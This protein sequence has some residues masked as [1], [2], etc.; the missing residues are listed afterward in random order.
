MID[1]LSKYFRREELSCKCGCGF[2]T[3]DSSLHS[4]LVLVRLFCGGAVNVN[5]GCRCELHNFNVGGA[6][7][8]QHL[9]GRA[10]DIW[11]I[12]KTPL[13]IFEFIDKELKWTGGLIL[14]ETFVHVDSRSSGKYRSVRVRN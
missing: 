13:Q 8:S 12:H 4:C 5:S 3:V 6:D 2:D 9:L 14:Y 1:K 7:D 10:A 11:S